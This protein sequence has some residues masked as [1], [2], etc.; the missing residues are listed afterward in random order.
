[1]HPLTRSTRPAPVECGGLTPRL[2]A[3]AM[4]REKIAEKRAGLDPYDARLFIVELGPNEVKWGTIAVCLAGWPVNRTERPDGSVRLYAVIEADVRAEFGLD[5][6]DPPLMP[7]EP[8]AS[9]G[10]DAAP[11]IALDRMLQALPSAPSQAEPVSLAALREAK[12]AYD[13][14]WPHGVESQLVIRTDTEG[15]V[16]S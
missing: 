14:R 2:A 10:V 13:K 12:A 11:G 8:L 5:G 7:D 3:I 6:A 4:L 1:M 9:R 15:P 16:A